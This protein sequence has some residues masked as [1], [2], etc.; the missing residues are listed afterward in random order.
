MFYPYATIGD[1]LEVCHS[2]LV[3]NSVVVHFEQPDEKFCFKV[4]ECVLPSYKI[5]KR[6][7]FTNAE[8]KNL[9]TFCRNN[10]SLILTFAKSGGAMNA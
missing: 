7:G 4:L 2:K 3:N 9:M 6:V 8:V 10:S 5:T 1:D